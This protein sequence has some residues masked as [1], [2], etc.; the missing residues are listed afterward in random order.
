MPRMMLQNGYFFDDPGVAAS[1]V[2][3]ECLPLLTKSFVV[4]CLK[5]SF[6]ILDDLVFCGVSSLRLWQSVAMHL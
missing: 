5:I 3:D 1:S 2:V 4:L 6:E